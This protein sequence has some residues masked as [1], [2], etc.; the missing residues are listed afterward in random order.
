MHDVLRFWLDRGVDGFRI[1]VIHR[2]AKDPSLRDNPIHENGLPGFLG[3]VHEHDE[4]HA[5]IHAF[6]KRIRNVVDAYPER[7]TVGEVALAHPDPAVVAGYYGEADQLHLAF[8]FSFLHQPWSAQR[9]RH[10]IQQFSAL[11]PD[12]AWP[13]WVLSNH[14]VPR[15]ATRYEHP[16]LGEARA[17]LAAALLLTLRGTPFLYYGEEIGMRNVPIP[18]DRLQDPLAW[19]IHPKI[20]RDPE[21]T[22]MPWNDGPGGGFTRG[23]PWLPLGEDFAHRNVDRQRSEAGSILQLYRELLA[24]RRAT[25]ALE[26]GDMRWLPAPDDVLAYERREGPSR[27]LVALNLGETSSEVALPAGRVLR[28]LCTGPGA[29]LPSRADRVGLGPCEGVVL[30]PETERAS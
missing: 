20:A 11:V 15:H 18:E 28:G 26:R 4:N 17:R 6:L 16:T 5:D 1:D 29:A 13:C 19:T 7:M 27:A 21:R 8:S 3:Q 10:E 2:I 24:L 25:P 9:L 12:G 23:E 14:D 22:P 30:V